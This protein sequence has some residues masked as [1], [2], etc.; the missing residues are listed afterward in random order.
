MGTVDNN[1][2]AMKT[3]N[4]VNPNTEE[5]SILD[6]DGKLWVWNEPV[7][8]KPLDIRTGQPYDPGHTYVMGADTSSGEAGDHSTVEIFD[9]NTQEQVAELQIRTSYKIFAQMIDFLGRWYNNAFC[10]VERT[11]I[12]ST[13]CQELNNDL[14]YQNLYRRPKKDAFNKTS[15]YGDVGFNTG[16]S[17]KPFLIKA[18][19]DNIG[20]DR[21]RIKSN[22]LVKELTIYVHLKNGKTGAEPGKGN[23]DDLVMASGLALVGMNLAT[24]QDM[25][26][27]VPVRSIEVKPESHDAATTVSQLQQVVQAGGPSVLLPVLKTDDDAKA[28]MSIAQELGNFTKQLGGMPLDKGKIQTVN[29]Q[30]H[31]IR[32]KK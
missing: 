24:M 2:K 11:G 28:P 1:Y 7:R 25:T 30:K 16:P 8:S 23:N 22:R 17:T 9:L 31:I 21:M 26:G 27:L 20:K 19:A 4:Y 32:Y 13:I 15:K 14:M 29:P 10:V 18:L 6:F 12:G 5:R 3:A